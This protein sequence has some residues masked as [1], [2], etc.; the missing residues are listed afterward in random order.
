MPIICSTAFIAGAY[1]CLA[2]N[3]EYS[4]DKFGEIATFTNYNID[5]ISTADFDGD[6]DQDIAVGVS[7]KNGLESKIIIYENRIQKRK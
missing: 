1:L 3:G 4:F 7:Q 5:A 2:N 6:G